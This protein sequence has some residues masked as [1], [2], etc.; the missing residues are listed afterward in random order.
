MPETGAP[1]EVHGAFRFVV[2]IDG[3]AQAAF[4]ECTLPDLEVETEEVREGGLNEFVHVLPG[5]LKAGRVR[6]RHGITGSAELLNWYLQVLQGNVNDAMRQ[7]T[8]I[9]YDEALQPLI[10]WSFADAYPVKW[11]GPAFKTD[12]SAVAIETLELAHHGV[13]VESA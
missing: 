12:G 2:E 3:I 8:V 10:R 7:V 11:V 13:T 9:M 5:G 4:T 1:I 6:L